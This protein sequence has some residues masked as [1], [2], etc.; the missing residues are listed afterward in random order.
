MFQ[1]HMQAKFVGKVFW[2]GLNGLVRG[3]LIKKLP[4]LFI[5]CPT[6]PTKVKIYIEKIL[7]AIIILYNNNNNNIKSKTCVCIT[8]EYNDKYLENIISL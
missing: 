4:P 7:S 6:I 5:N 1:G 2:G 3:H 8:H